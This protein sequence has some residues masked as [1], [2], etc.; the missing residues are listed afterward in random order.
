MLGQGANHIHDL[1]IHQAKIANVFFDT[2]VRNAVEHM[3]ENRRAVASEVTV[4]GSTATLGQHHIGTLLPLFDQ[5][6][7]D[8]DRVL[9]VDV[10]RDHRIAAG[11]LQA[12]E[13]CRLLAEVARKVDQ[14]HLVV[15][16]RQGR[17]LLSGAVGTAIVDEHNFDFDIAQFQLT[18]HGLIKQ[19]D[20]LLFIEYR[21]DQ[22]NLHT[23]RSRNTT[24]LENRK[25]STRLNAEN[26]A[27]VSRPCSRHTSPASPTP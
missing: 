14:Q 25:P 16:L 8:A 5:L 19:V 23:P 9:Q 21:D 26:N 13:Q 11:I 24:Y 6:R 2:R 4:G 20:R 10:H 22:R 17:C 15:R 1:A 27:T 3:V 7:D 18:A 12:G